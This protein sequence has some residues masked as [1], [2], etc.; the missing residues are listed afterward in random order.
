MRIPARCFPP[1]VVLALV[2]CTASAQQRSEWNVRS[3]LDL[4]TDTQTVVAVVA[5]SPTN[6]QR[7]VYEL[8][9]RCDGSTRQ[10][11]VSTFEVVQTGDLI[12]RQIPWRVEFMQVV[13]AA[14]AVSSV[15]LRVRVDG[16]DVQRAAIRGTHGN[17][18]EISAVSGT[19]RNAFSESKMPTMPTTRLVV[20]DVFPNEQVEFRF[21]SMSAAERAAVGALC[22]DFEE[23][24]R[25][26]QRAKTIAPGVEPLPNPGGAYR[27]GSGVSLPEVISEYKPQYTAEAQRAKIQGVVWLEA[28]V[29]PDGTVGDVRVTKSLDTKYGLDEQAV[30]AARRWR[31]RPGIK[32]G[33]PVPV[34]ITL[35]L[36]FTLR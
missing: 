9:L 10:V 19:S 35:E 6:D 23:K 7:Y 1:S 25:A 12:P 34:Q 32:G 4:L 28:V 24:R 20:A 3:D 31:F 14:G 29:L 27:H 17:Q 26:E 13:G 30:K 2:A 11:H 36:T 15:D 22:F 18:G 21:D 5:A 16:G 8:T 33:V